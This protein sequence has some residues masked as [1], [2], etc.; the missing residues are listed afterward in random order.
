MSRSDETIESDDIQMDA[1]SVVAEL[2]AKPRLFTTSWWWR[3]ALGTCFAR[4]TEPMATLALISLGTYVSGYAYGAFLVS[5]YVLTGALTA[6]ASGKALD[7]ARNP[8]Q[9]V[10]IMTVSS[11]L[12]HVALALAGTFRLSS[13]AITATTALCAA[14]PGGLPGLSRSV[15]V[16]YADARV[17]K[18]AL[19]WDSIMTE[20]GWIL[21]PVAIAGLSLFGLPWVEVVAMAVTFLGVSLFLGP[22]VG[23]APAEARP[24][25]EKAESAS[26]SES[27][28]LWSYRLARPSLVDSI[29]VGMA[30]TGIVSALPILLSQAGASSSWSGIL[31][32]VLAGTGIAG[33][34]CYGKA[35]GRI[36]VHIT[37]QSFITLFGVIASVVGLAFSDSPVWMA[38]WVGISGFFITPFNT[39]RSISLEASIPASL[40]TQ[41][42][43]AQFALFG[44]GSAISAGMLALISDVPSAL[45]AIGV[46]S[47]SI[48]AAT[49]AAVRKQIV[50]SMNDQAR[51]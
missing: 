31:V 47:L 50:A 27:G 51:K 9:M 15:L 33:T 39:Q 36:A 30:V 48:S 44:L 29:S 26:A 38:I 37:V 17:M 43:S 3:W 5:V 10:M 12:L 41:G 20:V 13:V 46:I 49:N 23:A 7:R 28:S 35:A 24:Q 22:L 1:P 21:G 42:F 25:H 11:F 16:K 6:T 18:T 34:L 19:S 4:I 32:S 2:D 40:H 8:R 14:L 45:L